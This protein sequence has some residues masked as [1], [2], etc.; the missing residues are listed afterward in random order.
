MEFMYYVNM[1]RRLDKNHV[2]HLIFIER[3]FTKNE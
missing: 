3:Y 1:I 2:R